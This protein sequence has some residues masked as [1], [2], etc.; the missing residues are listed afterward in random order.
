VCGPKDF[1]F[2]QANGIARFRGLNLFSLVILSE[3][4]VQCLIANFSF[5]QPTFFFWAV[6]TRGIYVYLCIFSTLVIPSAML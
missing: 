5:G 1:V 6:E 3:V 4:T 2:G